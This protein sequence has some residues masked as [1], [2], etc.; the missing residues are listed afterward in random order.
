MVSLLADNEG[1]GDECAGYTSRIALRS[2]QGQGVLEQP[3][4]LPRV[5][6]A[7]GGQTPVVVDQGDPKFAR[8]QRAKPG[9]GFIVQ[10]MC[11]L[12]VP[13]AHHHR[14]ELV[15]RSGDLSGIA[16]GAGECQTLLQ[17]GH[18]SCLVTRRAQKQTENAERPR[19]KGWA[20]MFV[21]G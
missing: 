11:L 16:G 17:A 1:E 6:L 4:G 21:A 8:G 3:D 7:I 15:Q 20:G 9:E 10:R 19:A 13:L 12:E 2:Q 5:S 18:G 14:R